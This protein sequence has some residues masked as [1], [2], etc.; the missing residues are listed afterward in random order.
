MVTF[1]N[2]YICLDFS[3]IEHKNIGH[4]PTVLYKCTD[5]KNLDHYF[6]RPIPN[7]MSRLSPKLRYLILFGNNFTGDIPVNICR[8]TK[9]SSLQLHQNL[10]NGSL[11]K[12]I[13]YLNDLEVLNLSFNDFT[14]SRLPNK[15]IQL[16]K[17]KIFYIT[18][19][20]LNGQIRVY[21]T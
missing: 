1:S 8:L 17:V 3:L 19:T 13:G 4:F 11:P 14:P 9:L 20:N 21:R 10:F 7:D 16:K 2:H 5:L 15:F 6:V 18:E 12:E